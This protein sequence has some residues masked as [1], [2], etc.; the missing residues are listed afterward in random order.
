MKEMIKKITDMKFQLPRQS[1]EFFKKFFVGLHDEVLAAFRNM[2][3]D[4]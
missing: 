3:E 1:E 4:K 2:A